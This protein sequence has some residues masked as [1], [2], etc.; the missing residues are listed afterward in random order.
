L[1]F[2]YLLQH[3]IFTEN[4]SRYV[5]AALLSIIDYV[6]RQGFAITELSPAN[7][8]ID[9]RTGRLKVTVV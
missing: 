2:E 9:I 6:H 8:H 3:H 1:S 4:E 5:V 7:I